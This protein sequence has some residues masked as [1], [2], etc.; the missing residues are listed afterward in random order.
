MKISILLLLCLMLAP[1]SLLAATGIQG[2]VAWRGELIPGVTVRAYSSIDAIAAEEVIAVSKPTAQD[3]TYQLELP[4]GRYYLTARNFSTTPKPGDFFC[5]YSG[6]PIVVTADNYRQVG[7]NMI[8]VPQEEPAKAGKR[9][10]IWGE[11][12]FQDQPLERTYLYV[13]KSTENDFKGPAWFVQPVEKGTFRM[14]LPPGDY[15]L[16][17]RKR[18][19]GGQY[20][21]IEIGD[22]FNFYYGNPLHIEKNELKQIQLETITRLSMLEEDPDAVFSGINGSVVGPDAKPA[23][24]VRVFAYRSATMTGTPAYISAVTGNDGLFSLSIPEVGSYWLLAREAIG[25]P[26]AM[27]ELYGKLQGSK[28]SGVSLSAQQMKREVRIDVSPHP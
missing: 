9:S 5:Y 4:V 7:F 27:G 17:A 13:Y 11:I 15:W 21:P 16:L 23:V 2:R 1:S 12:S 22:Y 18:L 24:G 3:G 28:N 26:A 10:G 6:A 14:S 25:G 8:R 19:K 20:G